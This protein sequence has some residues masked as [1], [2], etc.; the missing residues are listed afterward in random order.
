M[1]QPVFNQ[2]SYLE[3]TPLQAEQRID[4]FLLKQLKGVPKSHIYR[5]LRK[6]EVRVNKGRVKPVYKLQ[7]GDLV[8][9]PPIQLE[10]KESFS[11]SIHQSSLQQLTEAIIHE[12]KQ[13]LVLNK[14]AGW[15]VHGGSGIHFGVIEGLRALYPKAPYLELVHRLDRDTSGCLLIAKKPAML[16]Q[17]HQ[18]LRD[19]QVGKYYQ[20]L[21]QGDWESR[22]AHIN[23]PLRKNTLKSGER[24]VRVDTSGKS[25]LSHF[26]KK[27]QFAQAALVQVKLDTGRTHQ[28]RVHASHTGHPIAGDN[29]YGHDEFNRQMRDIGLKRLFLHA[30]SLRIPSIDQAPPLQFHAPLPP[31]LQTVLERLRGQKK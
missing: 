15:A 23:L 14:P 6:G 16:R 10:Q 8:R 17:L 31:A 5:I 27:Q 28:I 29:K 3:I 19:N 20:A 11:G 25:A 13:L 7:A 12:D 24:I 26:Q 18:L 9:I 2:V 1:P 22:L 4:N 30:E 21:I